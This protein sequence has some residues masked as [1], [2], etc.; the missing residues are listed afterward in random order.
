MPRPRPRPPKNDQDSGLEDY[1]PAS[2]TFM[3]GLQYSSRGWDGWITSCQIIWLYIKRFVRENNRCCNNLVISFPGTCRYRFALDLLS[4]VG[5]C[6]SFSIP[7][8]VNLSL[9]YD[10]YKITLP[11][12]FFDLT[13]CSFPFLVE[14]PERCPRV[15]SEKLY[16][17]PGKTCA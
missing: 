3:K 14:K 9:Y 4:W 16:W 1:F 5:M 2:R 11:R 10:V 7:D 6:L 13:F 8:V 12:L 15:N 17:K